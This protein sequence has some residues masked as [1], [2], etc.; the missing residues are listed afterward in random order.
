MA[1]LQEDRGQKKLG[2]NSACPLRN[3]QKQR[4]F[5]QAVVGMMNGPPAKPRRNG[6]SQ[7]RRGG[8][9]KEQVMQT[10]E[11]V[12]KGTPFPPNLTI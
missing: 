7:L 2:I 11:E 3:D 12:I 5:V 6:G 1:L 4:Q 10:L 8:R 9:E